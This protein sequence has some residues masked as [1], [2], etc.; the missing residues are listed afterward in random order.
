M[1]LTLQMM[2]R[3]EQKYRIFVHATV[4]KNFKAY[5]IIPAPPSDVY[6]ALTNPITIRLWTAEEAEM[7]TVPGSEF[8]LW[9]GSISGRNIEFIEN[10][11]IVQQWYFDEVTDDSIVTII[12]H[13]HQ[14]GTS[15][16]VRH[17]NIPDDDYDDIV[18]GWNNNYFGALRA[19]YEE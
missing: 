19:F 5:Y 4:M 8:A 13:P 6:L 15:V 9:E 17:T 3:R 12:L 1:L 18:A 7:S 2:I 10:R 14:S 11:K 16:E